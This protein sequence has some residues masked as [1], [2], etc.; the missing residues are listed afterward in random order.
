MEEILGYLGD[1]QKIADASN[2]T[3]AINTQGFNKTLDYIIERL[4]LNT[5]F[6]VN[7]SFFSVRDFE[8]DGNPILI[9][10]INGYINNYTY[11]SDPAN[12]EFL[13]V[14]Y[15]ISSNLSNV[16]YLTVIPNGGCTA[17][18]WGQA[19]APTTGRVALIK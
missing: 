2:G 18:D 17:D 6:K 4:T 1:L 7:K 3:R 13:H 9:S 8:L 16:F 5:N 15:S 19:S 11:S 10:S 12:A 14:K